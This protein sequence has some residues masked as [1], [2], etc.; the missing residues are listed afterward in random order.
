MKSQAFYWSPDS[1]YL[2]FIKFD[3]TE[4][5]EFEIPVYLDN[6]FEGVPYPDKKSIKYPKVYNEKK[7]I[8][9]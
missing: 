8:L 5:P 9:K 6:N 1:K 3:D 4:V 2:G 7:I